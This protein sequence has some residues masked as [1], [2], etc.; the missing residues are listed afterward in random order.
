MPPYPRFVELGRGRGPNQGRGDYGRGHGEGFGRGAQLQARANQQH[1][2]HARGRRRGTGREDQRHG[3]GLH[4]QT[5]RGGGDQTQQQ[6]LQPQQQFGRGQDGLHAQSGRVAGDQSQQQELGHNGP[7][8]QQQFVTVPSGRDKAESSQHGVDRD[9]QQMQ[10]DQGALKK[11]RAFCFRCKSNGHVNE[12]CKA[13]LDCIICNKKNSHLSAKCP[14]LKMPEP[15]ASFFG[16]GKKEFA[17][18]RITDVD[19]KLEVDSQLR[20]FSPS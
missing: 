6:G 14:I 19:Y 12:N 7:Q 2:P 16:S 13:D 18:I 1:A 3:R 10:Q 17:F 8:L 20:L 5:G 9:A 4:T 11:K 15:N